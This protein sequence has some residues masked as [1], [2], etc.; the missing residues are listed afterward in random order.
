[1]K[2]FSN[3]TSYELTDV[4]NTIQDIYH[5]KRNNYISDLHEGEIEE[6]QQYKK[7]F[8][9]IYKDFQDLGI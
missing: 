5:L 1:M 6:L 3:L 7:L 8:E 9:D 2:R 4:Q